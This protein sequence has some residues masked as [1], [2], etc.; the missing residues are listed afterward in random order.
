ME[1]QQSKTQ[2]A[3]VKPFEFGAAALVLLLVIYFGVVGLIS[4]VDFAIEQFAK[5]WYF[6]VP[7][8]LGFGILM[9]I[10]THKQLV[11]T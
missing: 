11:K 6:I 1:L 7:L 10:H 2:L 5:F 9:S 4:G 8:A 3:L